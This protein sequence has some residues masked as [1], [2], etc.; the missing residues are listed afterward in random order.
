MHPS[1]EDLLSVRDGE[2]LDAVTSNVIAEDATLEREIDGMRQV[3]DA[4]RELPELSPADDMWQR[5]V[6][7]ERETRPRSSY[8]RL[9]AGAG[10]AAAVAALAIFVMSSP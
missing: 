10:I 2:P 4:L 6:A 9:A 3:R 8:R 7:V 5:I 1:T